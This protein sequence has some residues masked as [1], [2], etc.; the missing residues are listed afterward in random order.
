MEPPP[1]HSVQKGRVV[2]VRPFGLFV[3]MEGFARDGLVH[4][5]QVS[6]D[7]TFQREAGTLPRL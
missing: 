3:R 1:L 4:M 5:S 2:S 6:D 7:L